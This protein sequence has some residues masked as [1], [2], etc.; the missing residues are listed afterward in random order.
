[1]AKYRVKIPE[2]HYQ[3]VEI[4]ADSPEQAASLVF[5]DGEGDYL[6]DHLEF[7]HTLEEV[8]ARLWVMNMDT[9]EEGQYTPK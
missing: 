7:S 2:V 4:E 3:T 9:K 1:M 8:D 5:N 6:D